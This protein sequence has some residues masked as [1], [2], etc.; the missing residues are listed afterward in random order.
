MAVFIDDKNGN[1]SNIDEQN[2]VIKKENDT[3][4]LI[5]KEDE[6]NVVIKKEDDDTNVVIK[7]EDDNNV[8]IKKEDHNN[9]VVNKQNNTN[10]IIKTED[11]TNFVFDTQDET[12]KEDDT[13]D[14]YEGWSD[15]YYP[16]L[17]Y[18]SDLIKR[19]KEYGITQG[20]SDLWSELVDH[21]I[22]VAEEIRGLHDYPVL[23]GPNYYNEDDQCMS[24]KSC[25][26]QGV[27]MCGLIHCRLEH[28][29]L[30]HDGEFKPLRKALAKMKAQS[31][32]YYDIDKALRTLEYPLN[33]YFYT[34]N[35]YTRTT[36]AYRDAVFEYNHPK[37]ESK[38]GKDIWIP[39]FK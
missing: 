6:T 24:M 12:K 23:W 18:E 32:L 28:W 14:K 21:A 11:D 17:G 15:F 3:N 16:K 13:K 10:V 33:G 35:D 29:R 5:K 9:I 25:I 7:K 39:N 26:K 38:W 27:K 37:W 36:E 20:D 8:I 34:L 31:P 2:V 1:A 19:R 30:W 22:D 4:V